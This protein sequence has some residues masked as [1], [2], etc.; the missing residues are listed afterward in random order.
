MRRGCTILYNCTLHPA[1]QASF[2]LC[3]N[4]DLF[5][6][7]ETVHFFRPF[8][9]EGDMENTARGNTEPKGLKARVLP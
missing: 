7:L 5:H 4:D 3:T 6:R 9:G 8:A 1:I 2:V